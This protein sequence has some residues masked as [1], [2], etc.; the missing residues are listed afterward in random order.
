MSSHAE[1]R[2][3]LEAKKAENAR[4]AEAQKAAREDARIDDESAYE[5]ARAAAYAK[6]GADK[7]LGGEVI[8]AGFV[9][10]HWPD[11]VEWKHFVNKGILKKDG[12]TYERCK[13]LCQ[14]CL[15]YPTLEKFDTLCKANANA[16]IALAT[17]IVNAM[18]PQ[19]EAEGNE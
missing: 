11:E 5:D 4:I 7:V 1:K 10:L 12:L 14:R 8:G 19:V 9:L 3:A 16:P 15:C 13:D 6:F 17:R 18:Q 2:K